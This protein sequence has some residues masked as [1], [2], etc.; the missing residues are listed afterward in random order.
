MLTPPP[1][2]R[3]YQD[4]EEYFDPARYFRHY[5]GEKRPDEF[6]KESLPFLIKTLRAILENQYYR[7]NVN[8]RNLDD[9]FMISDTN[10]ENS[11]TGRRSLLQIG[12]ASSGLFFAIL[13]EKYF[14]EFYFLENLEKV[15][16]EIDKWS[17]DYCPSTSSSSK[18]DDC[19]YFDWDPY[20]TKLRLEGIALPEDILSSVKNK[21]KEV[22]AIDVTGRQNS[23]LMQQQQTTPPAKLFDAVSSMFHI[24]SRVDNLANYFEAVQNISNFLKPGGIYFQAGML[25]QSYY[26]TGE[27]IYFKSL[28]VKKQQIFDALFAAGI[29]IEN[30]NDFEVP[31]CNAS[32]T[33]TSPGASM[34]VCKGVK[35]TTTTTIIDR[36]V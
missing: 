18:S 3:N 2:L 19:C 23:S 27:N 1:K 36:V 26:D 8:E 32:R 9:N 21:I 6:E 33:T 22:I 29:E 17:K 14:N 25:N 31:Y 20:V 11:V 30:W 15:T 4:L 13:A 28:P 10:D 5:Y 12:L 34:Y 35:R 7:S 16:T 24:E